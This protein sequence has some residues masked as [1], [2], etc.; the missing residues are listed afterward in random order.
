MG[1]SFKYGGSAESSKDGRSIKYDSYGSG[2]ASSERVEREL[3]H[4]VAGASSSATR[5][6]ISTVGTKRYD[7]RVDD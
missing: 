2:E 1:F 5:Q 4:A 6:A 3:A 7:I